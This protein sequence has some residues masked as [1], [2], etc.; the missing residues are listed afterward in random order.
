MLAQLVTDDAK[1]G[2][3]EKWLVAFRSYLPLV[4]ELIATT[5]GFN[6]DF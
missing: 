2:S 1:P 6:G 4:T 3:M 5:S